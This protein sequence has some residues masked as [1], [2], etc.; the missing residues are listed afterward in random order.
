M[1]EI[2][3]DGELYQIIDRKDYVKY[4]N[5]CKKFGIKISFK[6]WRNPDTGK[7]I[8][9]YPIIRN[10]IDN[11]IIEEELEKPKSSLVFLSLSGEKIISTNDKSNE[12]VDLSTIPQVGDKPNLYQYCEKCKEE[13]VHYHIRNTILCQVCKNG[14]TIYK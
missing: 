12:K 8:V 4:A 13:T 3:I 9:V 10:K 6:S 5:D 14:Y 7:S 11:P 1:N 2:N